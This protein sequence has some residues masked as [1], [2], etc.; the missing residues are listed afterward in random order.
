MSSGL[1]R[2]LEQREGDKRKRNVLQEE[3][4]CSGLGGSQFMMGRDLH[5]LKLN[6]KSYDPVPVVEMMVHR[7]SGWCETLERTHLA[8]AFHLKEQLNILL[9]MSCPLR[10]SDR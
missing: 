10:P 6:P 4:V 2:G 5:G 3:A 7:D 8:D 9:K 1:L